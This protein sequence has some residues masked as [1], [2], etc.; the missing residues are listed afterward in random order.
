MN[1]SCGADFYTLKA[2]CEADSED[3]ACVCTCVRM[4]VYFTGECSVCSANQ[5]GLFTH[6]T[7]YTQVMKPSESQSKTICKV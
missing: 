5:I 7:A 2:A 3:S 4:C 6:C 1:T